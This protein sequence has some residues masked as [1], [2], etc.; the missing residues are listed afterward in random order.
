MYLP[1]FSS[2]KQISA[3][4]SHPSSQIFAPVEFFGLFLSQLSVIIME[5][6]DD[7]D[8]ER[9]MMVTVTCCCHTMTMIVVC[10]AL[11]VLSMCEHFGVASTSNLLYLDAFF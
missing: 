1:E 7:D 6:D 8:E 4:S 5:G 2:D 3:T 9:D 11:A 10:E